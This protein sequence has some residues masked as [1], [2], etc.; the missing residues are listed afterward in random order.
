MPKLSFI[1]SGNY[2]YI[3]LFLIEKIKENFTLVLFDNHS[4]CQRPIFEELLSCG[5][6]VRTAILT[7]KFL[8]EVILVGTS[9]DSIGTIDPEVKHKLVILSQNMI[10]RDKHWW[11][12]LKKIIHYPTYISVDKDVFSKDTAET[13]WDQGQMTIDDFYYGFQHIEK[14]K[15]IISMDVCGEYSMNYAQGKVFEKANSRNNIANGILAQV[16]L[17]PLGSRQKMS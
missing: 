12:K 5:G 16:L 8:K 15:R 3:S 6:W 11:H 2:H 14:N 1:G 13:N 4:D 7:N 9:E 10:F 17:A